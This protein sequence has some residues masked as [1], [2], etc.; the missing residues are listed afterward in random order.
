MPADV[1]ED[2]GDR[3]EHWL[4]ARIQMDEADAL[5]QQESTTNN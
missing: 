1:A 3:W 5:I 2:P 4:F